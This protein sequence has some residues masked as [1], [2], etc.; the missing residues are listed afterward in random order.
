[1]EKVP[2]TTNSYSML[3]EEL[4]KL[5]SEDRPN[6]IRAI[7]EAREH[8]DLSENAE[9]HAAKEQQSFIEGRILELEYKVTRAEV[10]DTSTI[11]SNKILFGA[12]INLIDEKNEKEITYKIVGVDETNV[13][14]GLISVS[15]PVARSLMGKM[16]GDVA[17]VNTPGGKTT[18]EIL[19]IK[20]I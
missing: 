14:K 16:L 11:K 12:T 7:A 6:V 19:N 2:M 3:E 20:Y 1:M 15:S 17:V 8:G 5:K 9:Y 4:K 13:E 10:I 18:Y